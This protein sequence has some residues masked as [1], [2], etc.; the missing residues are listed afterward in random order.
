MDTYMAGHKVSGHEMITHMA[1]HKVSGHEMD[2]H[3]AGHKVNGHEMNTQCA[4][5]LS[6]YVMLPCPRSFQVTYKHTHMPHHAHRRPTLFDAFDG[7]FGDTLM[8]LCPLWITSR[9]IHGGTR[10]YMVNKP[11]MQPGFF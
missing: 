8:I 4:R 3:M 11:F 2:T 10:T 7:A 6:L 1:E 9:L 5:S